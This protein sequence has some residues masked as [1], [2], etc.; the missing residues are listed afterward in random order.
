MESYGRWKWTIKV[1]LGK[2]FEMRVAVLIS[3]WSWLFQNEDDVEKIKSTSFHLSLQAFGIEC[4]AGIKEQ[5]FE[6]I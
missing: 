1:L 4:Q 6:V 5:M 3:A 2:H